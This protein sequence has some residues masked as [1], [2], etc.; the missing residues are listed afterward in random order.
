[1]TKTFLI[2]DTH[3]GHVGVTKFLK[4]DG[5]KMRPWDTVEEMDEALIENWN[6]V[7]SP[8]DRVY[9]LGDLCMNRRYIHTIG[10]CNGRKV[11]IKGNHD[12]FKLQD[13]LPYFD[14]IRGSW[15]LDRFIL[16]HIPIH[17]DSINCR[18]NIHG[19]LHHR[20]LDDPRYFNVSVEQI[21]FTPIDFE[22][23]KLKFEERNKDE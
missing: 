14:D 8:Q 10:K 12:F 16:S 4:E 13:Y 19:H 3:F 23:L 17:P 22:E 18:G 2:S 6:K 7:V 11:L 5:T 9:H 1:M 21:N 20:I 15:R